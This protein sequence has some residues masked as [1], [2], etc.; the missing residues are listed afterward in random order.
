[1]SHSRKASGRSSTVLPRRGCAPRIITPCRIASPARC[2]A[3]MLLGRKNSRNRCR[4]R[5]AAGAKI[6][7]GIL[8]WATRFPYPSLPA[9][10]QPLRRS[11]AGR[12]PETSPMPPGSPNGM[13]RAFPRAPHTAQWP[14][15]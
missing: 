13:L 15:A 5:I 3:S 9:T 1:M 8:G 4:S 10:D 7:C 14:H 12:F 11:H 2:A 6:T